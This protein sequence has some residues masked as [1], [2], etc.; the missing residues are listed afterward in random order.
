MSALVPAA[1]QPPATLF[2]ASPTYQMACRQ[3]DTVA[4]VIDLDPDIAQRL[5]VPKRS[6]VVAVPIRMDSG[7]TRTFI[8]YR[9]QHSLTSG[10]SKGG[11]RYAP[12]VDLGEVAAL[13]M[14]M[15][16][17]CGI[18]NLPFSGAKGGIACD[19]AQLSMGEK[20]RMTRRFT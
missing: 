13:A 15:G 7:E 1:T 6:M 10:A 17:K 18:M 2:D 19:P 11:L 14:W 5:M 9:V 16:W 20:E 3:L 4:R 8:G 12:N